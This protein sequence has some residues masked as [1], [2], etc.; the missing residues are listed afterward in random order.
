MNNY[1]F[2]EYI[3]YHF[4]PK[5]NDSAENATELFQG[6]RPSLILID[7]GVSIDMAVL[8][9]KAQ[10]EF[11]FEK[12]ENR[13]PEMLDNKPWNYQ[14]IIRVLWKNTGRNNIHPFNSYIC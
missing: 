4:R 1:P 6:I 13:I 2:L 3:H 10:F 12:Q 9:E 5:L 8:P 7:F 14:V 11:Q